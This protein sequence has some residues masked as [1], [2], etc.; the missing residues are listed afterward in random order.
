MG[1]GFN[2]DRQERRFYKNSIFITLQTLIG[3]AILSGARPVLR[4]SFFSEKIGF[5]KSAADFTLFNFLPEN[6]YKNLQTAHHPTCGKL[7][8]YLE[9]RAKKL[10]TTLINGKLNHII[11]YT[12]YTKKIKLKAIH[13][14]P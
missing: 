13:R 5:L 7:L 12:I 10:R 6:F 4:I 14:P 3:T 9:Y 8:N 1:G 2:N 11:Y